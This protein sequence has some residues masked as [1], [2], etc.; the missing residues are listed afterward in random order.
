[1][2]NIAVE[3]I[4]RTIAEIP[5]A[6]SDIT[7]EQVIAVLE[8]IRAAINSAESFVVPVEITAGSFPEIDL[9]SVKPGDTITLDEDVRM[10]PRYIQLADGNTALVAF[11]SDEE[12]RKGADSHTITMDIGGFLDT[13]MM[14]INVSG[15]VINPWDKSF[16]L[17]KRN[18]EAILRVNLMEEPEDERR[19]ENNAVLVAVPEMDCG[20]SKLDEAINYAVSCHAGDTRKGTDI[21]YILHPLE[22]FQI[23][24][25]MRA[26]TN[27]LIAGV[28]HDT[29]EDTDATLDVIA[30]RFGRDVA[31]LVDAHSED[32]RKS[33]YQR[34][35]HTVTMLP[36]EDL[37]HKMLTIADKLSNM[38]S[39]HKDYMTIGDELWG[40]FNAPKE[41]L[42]WYYSKICDGLV[43]LQNYTN[44]EAAYWELTNL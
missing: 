27:L 17:T 36:G 40:R 39:I 4:E 38:R 26:D 23:L 19:R 20:N 34:K 7:N 41:M 13:A 14:N 16:Y 32:K 15:I 11:T 18:I 5:E 42:A 25:S 6:A 9:A 30:S 22:A 28:L 12:S 2:K 29:V 44:T 43:E 33:W 1:M 35:L 37:R 31:E 21:P 24:Y 8:A 3:Q 10:K